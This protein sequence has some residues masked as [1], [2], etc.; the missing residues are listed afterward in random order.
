MTRSA[1][2]WLRNKQ[3]ENGIYGVGHVSAFAFHSLRLIGHSTCVET[4]AE[5]LNT[6]I[7]KRDIGSLSGDRVALYILGAMAKC[8]IIQ[9]KLFKFAQVGI[10]HHFQYSLSVLALYSKGSG[11]EFN[12]EEHFK[13]IGLGGCQLL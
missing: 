10:D 4:R 2:K 7:I 11:K 12:R 13:S 1:V 3:D 8:Q 5:H 6:E 9:D